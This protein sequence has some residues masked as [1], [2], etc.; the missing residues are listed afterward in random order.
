[1]FHGDVFHSIRP[2][3]NCAFVSLALI[4]SG[5]SGVAPE[6]VRDS[7]AAIT[8]QVALA[9]ASL[10]AC[11]GGDR[12]QCDSAEKNLERVASTNAQLSRLSQQ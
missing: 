12:A 11:R 1:M 10:S 3:R 9:K 2:F 7:T 5:C 6:A 4:A 8:A